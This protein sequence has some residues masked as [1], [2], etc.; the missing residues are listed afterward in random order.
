MTHPRDIQS[1]PGDLEE[2]LAAAREE[3]RRGYLNRAHGLAELALKIEPHNLQAWLILGSTASSR[4][5]ANGYYQQ[6][7]AHMPSDMGEERGRGAGLS[8]TMRFRL[9]A[10]SSDYQP[11]AAA[12]SFGLGGAAGTVKEKSVVAVGAVR[13][14]NR[15][16]GGLLTKISIHGNSWLGPLIYLVTLLLA[17]A[18]T[19]LAELL[20]GLWLYGLL[21]FAMLVLGSLTS[22]IQSR[23]L[24]LVLALPPLIRML[25]LSLSQSGRLTIDLYLVAGG[26][27]F[28]AAFLASRATD[29]HGL[30]IGL[31]LRGWPPQILI[32]LWGWAL[33]F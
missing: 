12:T 16:L 32:G 9:A 20:V 26:L 19:S 11:E 30:R 33:A 31:T 23:R 1:H 10:R 21:F 13:P 22:H 15:T 3:L 5:E 25:S 6:A 14:D 18:L 7:L 29:L 4:A 8:N 24:L 2:L 17:E 28:L 27:I